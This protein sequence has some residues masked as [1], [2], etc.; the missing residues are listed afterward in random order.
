MVRE[1]TGDNEAFYFLPVPGLEGWYM[2][3]WD[4]AVGSA[5]TP[6]L[7]WLGVLGFADPAGSEA[8]GGSSPRV[9]FS[10]ACSPLTRPAPALGSPLQG[11]GDTRA[12]DGRG[13]RSGAPCCLPGACTSSQSGGPG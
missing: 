2:L 6:R 9:M 12:G 5:A 3:S 10:A 4:L 13:G 1:G 11:T 8:P 7:S